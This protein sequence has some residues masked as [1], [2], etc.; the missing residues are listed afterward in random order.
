LGSL[1][2]LPAFFMKKGNISFF[3]LLAIIIVGIYFIFPSS[4]NE[5]QKASFK[6]RFEQMLKEDKAF[7]SDKLKNAYRLLSFNDSLLV[8]TGNGNHIVDQHLNGIRQVKNFPGGGAIYYAARSG[9][10]LLTFNIDKSEMMLQAGDLIVKKKIEGL[11]GNAIYNKGKFYFDQGDNKI[12][13]S[14]T[15]IVSWDPVTNMLDTIDSINK[16]VAGQVTGYQDCLS[17]TLEGNFFKIDTCKV[18]FYFYYG[19][20][21]IIFENDK[22][23]FRTTVDLTHFR[24]YELKT[25][26]L[27]DGRKASQCYSATSSR[28]NYAAA[29]DGNYIY[30]LS[31]VIKLPENQKPHVPIDVYDAKTYSYRHTI[32]VPMKRRSDYAYLITVAG[33][34]LYLYFRESHL[35][36]YKIK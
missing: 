29:S 9:D 26:Q 22:S 15:V 6:R 34:Y 3:L 11:P 19:G 20:Y 28:V 5:I 16:L 14:K 2:G 10:S 33:D 32:S 18:G 4:K 30:M 35:T 7:H 27:A 21:F 12:S 23:L 1:C 8:L 24:K 31:G 36:R 25:V 13:G 17:Q